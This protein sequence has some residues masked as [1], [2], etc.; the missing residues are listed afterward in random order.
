MIRR[1]VRA[2][3]PISWTLLFLVPAAYV[4]A[5]LVEGI[6]EVPLRIESFRFERLWAALM[7]LGAVLIV[8]AR[9]YLNR[10]ALP[11]LKVSRGDD[12]ASL[13]RGWRV[14]FTD[15]PTGLRT[16]AVAL[17]AIALMGPQSIHAR[18]DSELRGIDIVL[19]LDVSLSMQAS[20]ITPNRFVATKQV[21]QNFVAR[22]PNDRIGSVVF[23][24][25]AYTLLPL[26]TDKEALQTVIRELE[27][28]L[29]DGRGTAIGNA[30]GVSLNRLR[31]SEA[32]SKVIILLT[33]G[34]S[35]AGNVSP[36]QAAE[37]AATM[38]V[39]VFSILMGQ[40]AQARVRRG[41]GLFDRG[42]FDVGNF[43]I[44]P[45]LLQNMSQRTGGEF[46]AVTDREGLERSFHRILDQLE[47]TEI[48]DAGITYGELFPAFV[49]PAFA[50]LLLELFI[51]VFIVRRWP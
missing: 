42:I 34:D 41:T 11:R 37:L 23:G 21:V 45:E 10:H 49:W 13:R 39:K 35:N 36:D 38:D 7:G 28:N 20:D 1:L 8:L 3:A 6:Y 32:K 27:L 30:V 16:A 9:G 4:C 14:W 25:D 2:L 51:G 26:T 31:R 47:K 46:F 50:L 19:T 43:P 12:L 15:V 48:E 29:I 24:R 17:L 40:S 22:R 5:F 18:N 44:N 33:D